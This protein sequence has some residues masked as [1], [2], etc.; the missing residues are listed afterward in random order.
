MRDLIVKLYICIIRICNE[1][2]ISIIVSYLLS[3]VP[4]K[5]KLNPQ[6]QLK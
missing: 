5:Y 3:K 6:I 4:T 2:P 1:M